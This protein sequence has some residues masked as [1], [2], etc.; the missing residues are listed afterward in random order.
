MDLT[1]NLGDLLSGGLHP[2]ETAD[3]L[4]PLA[5]PTVRGNHE[6]QVLTIPREL[7]GLSDGRARDTM[8]AE[9]LR[10][11]ASLPLACEPAPGVLMFHGTPN[12]DATYL[13]E[14]VDTDGAR[15][16]TA[17]EVVERLGEWSSGWGLMLCGHT[18]IPR[19]LRLDSGTLVVNPGSVG[20]PA[21]DDDEPFP[22]VM[23]AGSPG[24]RYAIVEDTSGQWEAAFYTVHYDWEAAARDAEGLNRPDV[25]CALRTGRV[26]AGR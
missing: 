17:D 7:M 23:E 4:I 1:V 11:F 9:H 15:A 8:T 16:A 19:S 20:W 12:D 10:W 18:H 2:A 5:L 25:A 21:Y 3:R 22:H 13:L 14:S 24:A 26:M 6:H